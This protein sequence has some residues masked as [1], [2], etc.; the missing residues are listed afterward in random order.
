MANIVVLGAQWGDEGKGK[1]IDLLTPS[2]DIVARYQGGH[3]AGH[4]VYVRGEKII[5]HLLP[6]G[7]LHDGKLCLI[8]NGVVIQPKSL[9][10]EMSKI[11][12]FGIKIGDRLA[13]SK[14]AHLILPYH[15]LVESLSEEMKGESKI[16]TTLRGIGPAYQDKAARIGIRMG[17]LLNL[18]LLKEKIKLNS[19]EKNIMLKH[20]QKKQLDAEEIY[21][22][23]KE[24]AGSLAD[25]IQDVTHILNK[26]LREG[27]SVLF[28]GAQGSLLD[29][30]HGTYPF[31]TSSNST[32]GGI[33]TGLGIG[34]K[35]IHYVLGV[36]KAY[37]T[38]VGGGPFP[39]EISGKVGK[40]ILEKGKEFGSTTGRPR[41][42]GWFD[43]VAASYSCWINGIDHIVLTKADILDGLD[44]IQVC[45]G[46]KYKNSLLSSFP[47]EPWILENVVPQYE[48]LKGWKEPVE[49]KR[50]YGDL[51]E[52]FKDYIKKIEDL[53]EARVVVI[54][55]GV[56][57]KD[58]ILRDDALAGMFDMEKV[59][60]E[61]D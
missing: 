24:Y 20:Y 10:E 31:V 14:N 51:P 2:F 8:G 3:N 23:Y 55:T 43:A 47:T 1:I 17:D 25:Y 44:D 60:A 30:D 42:C 33:C 7:I 16:G 46:Y 26:S 45:V 57:R 61:L 21:Q 49:A 29:I 52:E 6:S 39:T 59:R 54:S 50:E 41:R 27:C 15:N 13:I 38:R 12:A 28:E 53:V 37:A 11:E 32:A 56:E 19:I 34:P 18:S 4:T 48:I 58:T 9:L 5:L 22:E 40:H 35:A 36:S